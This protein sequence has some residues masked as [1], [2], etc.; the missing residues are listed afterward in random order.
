M[1][2]KQKVN[3]ILKLR[4]KNKREAMT[5]DTTRAHEMK[6]NSPCAAF[7]RSVEWQG[8]TRSDVWT[9]YSAIVST[10]NKAPSCA[11]C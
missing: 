7:H 9:V 4:D 5:R 2:V 10:R 1:A 3:A 8:T 11:F 6:V